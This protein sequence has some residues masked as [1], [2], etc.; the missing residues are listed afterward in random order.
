MVRAVDREKVI[1]SMDVVKINY[2][3]NYQNRFIAITNKNIYNLKAVNAV[4]RFFSKKKLIIR[5]KFPISK[6]FKIVYSNTSDQFVVGHKIYDLVY[7]SQHR[8]DIIEYLMRVIDLRSTNKS[9]DFYFV[10]DYGLTELASHEGRT[11][12]KNSEAEA[13]NLNFSEYVYHFLG[14]K[15]QQ[16][17]L[18]EGD[19]EQKRFKVGTTD[20]EFRKILGTGGFSKVDWAQQV[21]LVKHNQTFE[22]FAMKSIKIPANKFGKD[23]TTFL[24]QIKYEKQI[25]MQLKHPFIVNLK[26]AFYEKRRFFLV[27]GLVQGGEFLNYIKTSE[28]KKKEK[29]T[30]FYAAQIAMALNYMHVKGI[31]YGDLKPENILIDNYGY[32]K[33]TDFG[34]SRMLNGKRSIDA[35]AGTPDYLGSLASRS[36][37]DP[38]VEANHE[39]V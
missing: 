11:A 25:L 29:V 37:R 16:P 30:K 13:M 7:E 32:V 6:C 38:Q 22:L 10:E 28:K 4:S 5:Q 14:K 17:V 8:N 12:D 36:A 18:V 35:F 19:V 26:Y 34:A 3:N 9:I 2:R 27:M 23:K 21:Y 1:Y 15:K 39:D 20:F 33:M 24:Q 31:V